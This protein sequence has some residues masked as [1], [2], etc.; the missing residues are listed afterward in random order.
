MSKALFNRKD[1]AVKAAALVLPKD[2]FIKEYLA[3]TTASQQ[4]LEMIWKGCAKEREELTGKT[5]AAVDFPKPTKAEVAI[6]AEEK[7]EEL[8]E[9]ADEETPAKKEDPQVD[10]LINGAIAKGKKEKKAA[11]EK[12]EGE[13]KPGRTPRMRELIKELGPD[14]QKV[15]K[16]LEEEGFNCTTSG[17]HSEWNRIANPKKK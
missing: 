11:P 15:R 5:D 6:V 2:Q 14:K 7:K 8:D 10:A 12:K 3:E 13:D 9:E 4:V 16:A 1:P 17:F